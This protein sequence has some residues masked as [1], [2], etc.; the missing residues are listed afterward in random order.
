MANNRPHLLIATLMTPRG[1]CGVQTHFNAIATLA[2]ESG[3]P[4]TIVGPHGAN[5]WLRRIPGAVGRVVNRVNREHAVLWNRAFA[6]RFLQIQL[7]RALVALP[8]QAAVIY[9]Q[10]P[11]SALAA[12][13][14]RR[15]GFRFRLVAVVHF[16]ISEAYE[17]QLAGI[18]REGS[19]LWHSLMATEQ[20]ALPR[21]D[22][23]VFVSNFM[24]RAVLERLPELAAVPLHVIHNFL[25]APDEAEDQRPQLSGDLLSI[26]TL[27]P[28]KNQGYLLHVL[29]EARRR[30]HRFTL[31]LAGDGRDNAALRHEARRLGIDSQVVFAGFVPAAARLLAT[32]RIL[33][34]AAHMENM[35]LTLI[36][37]LAHGRPVLAP[38]VGGIPE[39]F[40]D[41][42]E[43]RFWPLT[44]CGKAAE[45]LIR[46]L[47]DEAEYEQT[48]AAA[49]RRYRKL[50]APAVLGPRWLAVLEGD[51]V[52][53][54]PMDAPIPQRGLP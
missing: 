1:W 48:R 25:P 38:A 44:D 14:L 33:V 42:V 27:E 53:P 22:A 37:A 47:E 32:H 50:F 31:T 20:A 3:M 36:E 7:R 23:I 4:V 40:A 51:S 39:I 24:R 15:E 19:C 10:D 12:L 17:T 43:G 6:R 34:H 11:L 41:G 2:A 26:G 35:P 46:L 21:V 5:R 29:A 9:A 13:D 16:N 54:A 18:S 30:G 52:I 8:K 49:F 45:C 28:R